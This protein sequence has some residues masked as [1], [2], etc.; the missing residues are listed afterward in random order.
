MCV[1]V[2]I[3]T[4]LSFQVAAQNCRR[5]KLGLISKLRNELDATRRTRQQLMDERQNL[6]QDCA[7]WALRVSNA[8]KMVLNGLGKNPRK[9]FLEI[10]DQC[11]HGEHWESTVMIRKRKESSEVIPYHDLSE[12]SHTNCLDLISGTTKEENSF[13]EIKEEGRDQEDEEKPLQRP[14]LMTKEEILE[15][16]LPSYI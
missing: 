1:C 9:Y 7:E 3:Y 12:K 6:S 15:I 10:I 8:K 14:S 11:H 4:F 5:R 16:E 13:V 2:Y